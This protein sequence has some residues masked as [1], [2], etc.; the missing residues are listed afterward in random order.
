M[1]LALEDRMEYEGTSHNAGRL[2]LLI[3]IFA[4]PVHSRQTE[5]KNILWGAAQRPL[6][7]RRKMIRVHRFL[8]NYCIIL[9]KVIICF[10]CI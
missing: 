5:V 8:C 1:L 6:W 9:R 4:L 10:R 3:S 7:P 2:G